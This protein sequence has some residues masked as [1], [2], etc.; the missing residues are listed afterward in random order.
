MTSQKSHF[1]VLKACTQLKAT[2][3]YGRQNAA[4]V[5]GAQAVLRVLKEK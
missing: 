3:N 5:G 2:S 1:A 4:L